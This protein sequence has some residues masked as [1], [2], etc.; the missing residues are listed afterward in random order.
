MERKYNSYQ[1]EEQETLPKL[2]LLRQPLEEIKID[3]MYIDRVEAETKAPLTYT[4]EYDVDA[5]Q[6]LL[7]FKDTDPE[8]SLREK[9]ALDGL[10][11]FN[12]ITLLGERLSA[13]ISER[14]DV[15]DEQGIMRDRFQKRA[16]IDWYEAGRMARLED[17]ASI[18]DQLREVAEVKGQHVIQAR[19]KTIGKMMIS[20]SPPGAEDSV[21]KHNFYD[22][23]HLVSD[24]EIN[25][26][27]YMSGLTIP[28]TLKRLQALGIETPLDATD[29]ELLANPF[30][31][32]LGETLCQTPDQIHEYLHEHIEN[33]LTRQEM[34]L[35]KNECM[36]L[37]N[38]YLMVVENAPC[39]TDTLKRAYNAIVNKAD[40]VVALLKSGAYSLPNQPD[41]SFEVAPI[42]TMLALGSQQVRAVD[43]GCGFSGGYTVG[44][45]SPFG[46][47]DFARGYRQD[48]R[49]QF[50]SLYFICPS[51]GCRKE[52]K[53]PRGVLIP[54]CQHCGIDVSCGVDLNKDKK[55]KEKLRQEEVVEQ[56]YLADVAMF[57]RKKKE[58]RKKNDEDEGFLVFL[59]HPDREK[60]DEKISA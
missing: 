56:K 27:R 48:E 41:K 44:N 11:R 50:E 40:E 8:R 59:F 14:I 21:Y 36:P 30:E 2:V 45:S 35:V 28:E 47:L 22:I 33:S 20:I 9:E 52:N 57:E 19:L 17:G 12:M 58:Q 24:S 1:L 13:S 10:T 34:D 37:I 46:V 54:N 38:R 18:H 5:Y 42:A 55:K 51:S 6:K 4:L 16:L 53:R 49:D 3:S 26:I 31:I 32:E 23:F 7:V 15:V 60:K 25:V 39:V 29:I 43:T